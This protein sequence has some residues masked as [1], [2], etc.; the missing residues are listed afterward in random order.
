M[1]NKKI[2]VYTLVSLCAKFHAFSTICTIVS[3]FARNLADYIF[4]SSK[5]FEYCPTELLLRASEGPF[6]KG[7]CFLLPFSANI[8][9]AYF[10]DLTEAT[11]YP[12]N[13]FPNKF[14]SCRCNKSTS[15]LKISLDCWTGQLRGAKMSYLLK[16]VM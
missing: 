8:S 5:N 1:I 13:F 12:L 9:M 3:I 7:F 6:R 10:F 14:L 4:L 16:Y 15:S 2:K 11:R